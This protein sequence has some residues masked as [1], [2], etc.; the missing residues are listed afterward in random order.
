MLIR[1]TLV[2]YTVTIILNDRPIW[3]G[4]KGDFLS[5]WLKLNQVFIK[6]EARGETIYP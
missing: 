1:G 2:D 6:D 4:K 5:L 3:Q